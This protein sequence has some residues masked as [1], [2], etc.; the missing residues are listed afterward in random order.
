M[1]RLTVEEERLSETCI[2]YELSRKVLENDLA[3][4]EEAPLKLKDPYI[5]LLERTIHMIGRELSLTKM[6]MK[7]IGLKVELNSRDDTFSEYTIFFRGYAMTAKYMNAHL[8]NQVA[9]TIESCFFRHPQ[10]PAG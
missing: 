2:L 7:K 4:M 3:R 6:R 10:G 1:A 9:E 8:K 5:R